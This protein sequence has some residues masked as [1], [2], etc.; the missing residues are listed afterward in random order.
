LK[1][2]AKYDEPATGNNPSQAP[3]F[4]KTNLK[5]I[6][7]FNIQISNKGKNRQLIVIL[8]SL[9]I[10]DWDVRSSRSKCLEF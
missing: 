9:T 6:P 10:D 7:T 4:K 5:Q 2:E 3:N 8:I 1:P